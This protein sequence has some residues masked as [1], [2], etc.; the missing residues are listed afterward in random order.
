M[1]VSKIPSSKISDKH[2]DA[3]SRVG[4]FRATKKVTTNESVS[5]RNNSFGRS[6]TLSNKREN[7]TTEV[8]SVNPSRKT[9]EKEIVTSKNST[10]SHLEIKKGLLPNGGEFR[11][12]DATIVC[13]NEQ[14]IGVVA[15]PKSIDD[16]EQHSYE[17]NTK[18]MI[19]SVE[20]LIAK[21]SLKK[22][23][24]QN[25]KQISL[26]SKRTEPVTNNND[27]LLISKLNSNTLNKTDNNSNSIS[28]SAG[29]SDSESAN[30]TESEIYFV[31][32]SLQK[33]KDGLKERQL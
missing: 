19:Q 24:L 22:S 3:I 13:K 17:I 7:I 16:T 12:S 20:L 5:P 14:H 4:S 8:R 11:E 32:N 33:T 28:D 6:Q 9:S 25:S 27:D 21:D 30:F 18:N 31:S 26:T 2:L 23:E 15:I 10:I 1:N 29:F